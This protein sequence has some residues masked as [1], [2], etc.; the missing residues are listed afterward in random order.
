M[1]RPLTGWKKNLAN[2]FDVYEDGVLA[3]LQIGLAVLVT[4][5]VI[6]LFMLIWQNSARAWSEVADAATFQEVFQRGLGGFL[7]IL[8][9]LELMETVRIY[10][11]E[12]RVRLETVLIV[13][14]IAIGRHIIQLEYKDVSG[15]TLIGIAAIVVAL[16]GGYFLIRKTDAGK[17]PE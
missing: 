1:K 11:N 9:G 7:V 12:H 5:G 15:S 4:T 17:S 14:M 10:S 16:A 8:L 3:I 2:V 13:A 6:R